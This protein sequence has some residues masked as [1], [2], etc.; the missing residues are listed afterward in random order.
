ME[1]CSHGSSSC[2][3]L[4]KKKEKKTHLCPVRKNPTAPQARA[5]CFECWR[6]FL[7]C[8]SELDWL[9]SNLPGAFLHVSGHFKV[10]A[11]IQLFW[12]GP[13][14]NCFT[15][16]GPFWQ[17][18]QSWCSWGNLWLTSITELW[19]CP[20]L[21]WMVC[22]SRRAISVDCQS[23]SVFCSRFLNAIRVSKMNSFLCPFYNR[24][25][26]ELCF[27]TKWVVWLAL[28]F[29]CCSQPL[30]LLTGDLEIR[31]LYLQWET[32]WARK[33]PKKTQSTLPLSQIWSN[34]SRIIQIV[35]RPCDQNLGPFDWWPGLHLEGW[36]RSSRCGLAS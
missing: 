33:D 27:Y 29:L 1:C 7:W 32:Y 9:A 24:D 23:K 13:S 34:L 8:V 6:P 31:S 3:C 17:L 25:K 15:A 19:M 12:G 16:S 26:Y 35:G 11:G 28:R 30:S 4:K 22:R 21:Y 10:K 18:R 5:S 36:L 2:Y 14:W 20:F